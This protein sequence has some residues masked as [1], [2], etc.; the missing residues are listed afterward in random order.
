MSQQS[1]SEILDEFDFE[2]DNLY[3]I[4]LNE[5]EKLPKEEIIILTE[6]KKE[7][8]NI[9]DDTNTEQNSTP[10]ITKDPQTGKIIKN[11]IPS[12]KEIDENNE[13]EGVTEQINLQNQTHSNTC[14]ACMQFSRQSPNIFSKYGLC[15]DQ[16]VMV[17]ANT[18]CCHKYKERKK[19][20]WI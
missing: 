4:N 11:Y 3:E 7:I 8:D 20:A 17:L 6:D 1:I 2:E 10:W 18:A 15:A 19:S 5:D 9:I 12:R 14:G 16:G 13:K